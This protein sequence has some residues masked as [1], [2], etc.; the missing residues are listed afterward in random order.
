MCNPAR[1]HTQGFE[2]PGAHQ[3]IFQIM[4]FGQIIDGQNSAGFAGNADRLD[5]DLQPHGLRLVSASFQVFDLDSVMSDPGLYNGPH[6][7]AQAAYGAL[8]SMAAFSRSGLDIGAIKRLA[9]KHP[10]HLLALHAADYRH[11]LIGVK[12][13]AG[14]VQ[15]QH[16]YRGC[17]KNRP[18]IVT[19]PAEVVFDVEP[20]NNFLFQLL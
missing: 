4:P 14:P 19:F 1:Q 9:R 18:R 10:Q 6:H 12:N 11:R 8:R 3:F 20:L 17:F 13:P 16:P 15:K 7:A 5:A 2:L